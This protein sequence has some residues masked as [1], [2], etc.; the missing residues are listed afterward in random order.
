MTR[1]FVILVCMLALGVSSFADV[2]DMRKRTKQMN[3]F[4]AIDGTWEANYK[5]KM[6]SVIEDTGG[7][8][9]HAQNHDG[10]WIEKYIFSFSRHTET[11]AYTSYTRT[12]HNW[13]VEPGADDKLE[14][15][16]AFGEGK[17]YMVDVEN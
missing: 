15:F 9:V 7:W 4:G 10:V 8:I 2:K 17:A 13:Y 1:R 12:V 6:I 16:T 3:S 14:F 11:M 5:V